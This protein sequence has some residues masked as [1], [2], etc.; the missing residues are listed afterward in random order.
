MPLMENLTDTYEADYDM[1]IHP[2]QKLMSPIEKDIN[3]ELCPKETQ[4]LAKET[5]ERA[6]AS[7]SKRFDSNAVQ[8][9]NK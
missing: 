4:T 7:R 3:R 5:L 2:Y 6:Q 9:E 1:L 8:T